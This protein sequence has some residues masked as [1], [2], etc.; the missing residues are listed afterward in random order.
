[1]RDPRPMEDTGLLEKQ[2]GVA[3]LAVL[4]LTVALSA[5]AFATA[6]LVRT[7]VEAAANR[8]EAAQGYFLARGAIEAAVDSMARST[9]LSPAAS[10]G[11]GPRPEFAAGQRWLSYDFPGGRCVVEAVPEN[12]K[13]NVN[14]ATPEQL[15]GLFRALGVS[16]G[17]SAE[18]GRAIEDWRLP[19]ISEAGSV[20]DAYYAALSPP[21]RAQHTPLQ[22]LEELLLVKG[23]SRE[24]FFGGMEEARE[25]EWLRRPPLADLL[26]VAVTGGAINPNYAPQEVL[27]LLP[28]WDA[29]D[30]AQVLAVRERTPFESPGAVAAVAPSIA[31]GADGNASSSLTIAQGPFYT[32]TAT[33]SQP[34]S[35]ESPESK[36]RRSVRALVEIAANRPLYHQVMA[37]WDDWPFP[38]EPPQ[39]L[40]S[41]GQAGRN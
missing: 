32:L 2:R 27:V 36:V 6:Y 3:L 37:W 33:C 41:G 19:R 34:D 14:F 31:D 12:A 40:L 5:M 15:A 35:P 9:F 39:A 10:G 20:F 30:A 21:Y 26:T 7:E 1:M 23:M 28:G 38:N 13:L 25:G 8:I 17:E 29:A 4:W 24:L 22:Q 16:P 18:L 11:T